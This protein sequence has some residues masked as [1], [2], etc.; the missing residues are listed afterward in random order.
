MVSTRNGRYEYPEEGWSTGRMRKRGEKPEGEYDVAMMKRKGEPEFGLTE[1]D[2]AAGFGLTARGGT[3]GGGL[4]PETIAEQKSAIQALGNQWQI[5]TINW[6]KLHR[7]TKKKG[8][9]V[10]TDPQEMLDATDISGVF[11]GASRKFGEKVWEGIAKQEDKLREDSTKG[12]LK[13]S[14]ADY[15]LEG[16]KKRGLIKVRD[17]NGGEHEI[18]L[19]NMEE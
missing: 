17:P 12:G 11:S 19:D 4:S 8:W 9:E 6:Q 5:G 7:E 2:R 3:R 18:Q 13:G 10:L 1:M 16:L 15:A 14:V